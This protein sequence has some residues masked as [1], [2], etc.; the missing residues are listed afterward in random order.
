MRQF[1]GK[2]QD[3]FQ[4]SSRKGSVSVRCLCTVPLGTVL[5]SADRIF[6]DGGQDQSSDSRLRTVLQV[7][8][9]SRLFCLFLR[10]DLF[11]IYFWTVLF[12]FVLYVCVCVPHEC[13]MHSEVRRRNL[14][15]WN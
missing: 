14:I 1:Q 11:L 12:C 4:K 5:Q 10:F 15:V 6:K 3:S 7:A 2:A 8:K 13:P 9:L